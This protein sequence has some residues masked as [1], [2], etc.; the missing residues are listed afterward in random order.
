MRLG[1]LSFLCLLLCSRGLSHAEELRVAVEVR[2]EALG[3]SDRTRYETLQRQLSDLFNR[4]HWTDLIYQDEERIEATF[5]LIL[6]ERK[7]EGDY[8]AEVVSSPPVALSTTPTI[9]RRPS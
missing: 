9:R 3:E 5:T 6:L 8:T 2:A 4:T 7:G 1:I